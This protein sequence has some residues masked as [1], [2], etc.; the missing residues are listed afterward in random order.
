V[1]DWYFQNEDKKLEGKKNK[2]KQNN[3]QK[4][5]QNK[6]RNRKQKQE[7][8]SQGGENSMALSILALC[9]SL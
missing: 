6:T 5:K 4:K 8:W 9:L 1:A 3:N 2:Q 7:V